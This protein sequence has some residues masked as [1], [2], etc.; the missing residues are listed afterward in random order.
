MLKL[1]ERS[2]AEIEHRLVLLATPRSEILPHFRDVRVDPDS[3]QRLIREMQRFRGGIYLHDG[4]IDRSDLSP[5][6]RHQTPE[7][8]RSWHLLMLDPSGHVSACVWYLEHPAN[9]S[10][11]QL[12]VRRSPLAT[13]GGWSTVL[14]KAV[15]SELARARQAGLRYAEVGGW[16]VAPESRCSSE[17]LLLALAA[18]SLGRLGAGTLGMTTATVRHASATILRRL[19]GGPLEVDGTPVPSYYD[20]RYRCQMELLRFDSRQPSARY[21]GLIDLLKEKLAGVKVL[22]PMLLPA[23]ATDVAAHEVLLPGRHSVAA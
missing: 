20:P 19:G 1:L 7:D 15:E 14:W 9:V 21:S 6:G 4:A 23:M 12:R 16:A 13:Q 3:R 22:A 17:G 2:I 10:F 18:Y 8:E 11:E 5:D